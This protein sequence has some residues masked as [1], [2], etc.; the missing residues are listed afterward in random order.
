MFKL[1]EISIVEIRSPAERINFD[2]FEN[3]AREEKSKMATLKLK[4]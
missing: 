2:A 1:V 3:C 4:N